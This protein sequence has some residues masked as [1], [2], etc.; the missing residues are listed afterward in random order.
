MKHFTLLIVIT[1]LFSCNQN[2]QNNSDFN[3][4]RG[5]IELMERDTIKTKIL[6]FENSLLVNYDSLVADVHYIL[7]DNKK[8]IIG[9]LDN[10]LYH[11]GLYCVY[12]K[13][14]DCV[15]I[16]NEEG[17]CVNKIDEQGGGPT[18][19]GAIAN[20]DIN[21]INSEI[22]ITDRFRPQIMFYG[23]DG[24]FKHK[25]LCPFQNSQAY[26]LNDTVI[27][28]QMDPYQNVGVSELEHYNLLAQV[29]DT[30]QYKSLLYYP[31]QTGY[32]GS[33]GLFKGY[34]NTLYYKPLFSDSI[35]II[36][37]E[38]SYSLA[39]YAKFKNSVWQKHYKSKEFVHMDKEKGERL[40]RWLF[41]SKKYLVGYTDIVQDE[42]ERLN[43]MLYDKKTDK[44]F[45]SKFKEYEGL[46]EVNSIWG[47]DIVGVQDDYYISMLSND[48]VIENLIEPMKSGKLLIKD[49]NL[50][51]I[52]NQ[53][54]EDSNPLLILTQFKTPQ[55][56]E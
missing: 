52:L 39:Y 45:V 34:D 55:I 33:N 48:F 49:K 9:Q 11:N 37:S 19:Y 40:F 22:V 14:E 8:G 28:H 47:Y 50:F 21:P 41:D 42:N 1:I 18:E 24:N 32:R 5:N 25:R 54:D 26:L 17:V 15:Y 35:Y 30:I 16:Y 31:S 7:L 46:K 38:K 4:S 43:L 12:D 20:I 23:L 36:N 29:R 6:D 2:V 13:K 44:V 10:I 53:I 27:I 3:S 51:A 56:I